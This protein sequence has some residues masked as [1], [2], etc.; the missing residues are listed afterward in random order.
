MNPQRIDS[1]A[2]P[3]PTRVFQQSLSKP[4]RSDTEYDIDVSDVSVGLLSKAAEI[5][6]VCE[7]PLS[8]RRR[9]RKVASATNLEGKMDTLIDIGILLA[10]YASLSLLCAL[11]VRA[12]RVSS[13]RS[14]YEAAAT[15]GW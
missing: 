1:Q 11:L 9:A 5:R 12:L 6:S 4:H 3:R 10:V 14:T 7:M 13:E 2:H 8:R 15:R